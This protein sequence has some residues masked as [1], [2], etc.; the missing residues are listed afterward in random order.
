MY[1]VVKLERAEPEGLGII[2]YVIMVSLGSINT[3]PDPPPTPCPSYRPVWYAT[4]PVVFVHWNTGEF[5]GN[6]A[7]YVPGVFIAA[8]KLVTHALYV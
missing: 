7:A 3:S 6:S 5:P 4:V 8:T 2:P 1:G